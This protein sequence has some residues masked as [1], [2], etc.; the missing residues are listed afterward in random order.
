MLAIQ[1]VLA[2]RTDIAAGAEGA[3]AG[4]LDHH[5]VHMRVVSPSRQSP[6]AGPDHRQVERVERLRSVQHDAPHAPVA[7]GDHGLFVLHA[8]LQDGQSI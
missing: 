4:T 5:A 1:L 8:P 3:I 6:C 7:S 2:Q